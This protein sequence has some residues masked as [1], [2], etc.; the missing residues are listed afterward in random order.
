MAPRTIYTEI[1]IDAP[2]DRVWD[3]L[4]NFESY[5]DWNPFIKSAKCVGEFQEG[6][7]LELGIQPPGKSL[8][9]FK[10]VVIVVRQNEELRW[11]GSLPI[12]GLFVGEHYFILKSKGSSTEVVHGENFTGLLVPLLGGMIS[13]AEQGFVEMNAALKSRAES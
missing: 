1:E 5:P 9:T 6:E 10:P 8:S 12:P 13:A 3:V 11:K 2:R 7:K 4:T